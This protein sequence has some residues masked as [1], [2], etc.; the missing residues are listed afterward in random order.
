MVGD[1]RHKML[2]DL[3]KNY[4]K[5]TMTKNDVEKL[6][7]LP[8]KVSPRDGIWYPPPPHNTEERWYYVIEAEC[9][10]CAHFYVYF[11]DRGFYCYHYIKGQ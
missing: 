2:K 10:W 7:G 5:T 11:D 9:T 1:N 4:L 8:D 6:L 3:V